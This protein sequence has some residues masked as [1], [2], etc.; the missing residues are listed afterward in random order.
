MKSGELNR[1]LSLV[2]E[3]LTIVD[4]VGAPAEIG[5][6]LDHVCNQLRSLLDDG[7]AHAHRFN[8]N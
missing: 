5:A 1:A 3:A 7:S 8:D 2:E 6:T 4:N